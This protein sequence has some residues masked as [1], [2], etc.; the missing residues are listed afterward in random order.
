MAA[1]KQKAVEKIC[2]NCQ[3]FD[4][5]KVA[6]SR[7]GACGLLEPRKARKETVDTCKQFTHLLAKK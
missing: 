6:G 1:E 4:F 5:T 7:Y 2:D 3:H